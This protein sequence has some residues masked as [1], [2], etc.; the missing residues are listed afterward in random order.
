MNFIDQINRL[1]TPIHKRISS[2]ICKAIILSLNDSPNL[3]VC[4]VHLMKDEEPNGIERIGEFGFIS[5]PPD[6]SE[7]V[8]IF[9]NGDRSKGLIIATESSRYRL[10]LSQK[11][12]SALYNQNGD[13]I[14]LLKDEIR[15]IV[16]DLIAE[17]SNIQLGGPTI[18]PT[19]GVVTGKC[20]CA[21]TGAPHPD[22]SSIV[23]AKKV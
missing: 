16:K 22:V 13:C 7:A 23:K 8:V 19:D 14:K 18:D 9:A 17:S 12:S 6:G 10:K 15:M 20:I 11:G 2:M 4:K 5:N 21:Y 3:Q 1:L